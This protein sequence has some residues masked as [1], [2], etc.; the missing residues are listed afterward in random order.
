MV[1]ALQ[2]HSALAAYFIFGGYRAHGIPR[3]SALVVAGK[4]SCGLTGMCEWASYRWLYSH[5]DQIRPLPDGCRP[6]AS[7][8]G[9]ATINPARG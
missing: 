1:A 6:Q 7:C 9:S 4:W 8:K 2:S 3:S 5:L